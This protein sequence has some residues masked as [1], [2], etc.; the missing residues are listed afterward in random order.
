MYYDKY[1]DRNREAYRQGERDA[2][3]GYRSHQYDYDS[4]TERGYAYDDG[5]RKERYRIEER[6]EEHRREER[7]EERRQYRLQQERE[8]ERQRQEEEE[9][10]QQMEEQR[11]E[12]P[13]NVYARSEDG[14]K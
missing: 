2:E 7:E 9:Y 5:Y 8:W 10:Y 11:E 12:E 14:E 3:R 13:R 1:S 4:Y 6:E